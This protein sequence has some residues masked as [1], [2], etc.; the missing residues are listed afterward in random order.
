[1][2]QHNAAIHIGL[3]HAEARLSRMRRTAAGDNMRTVTSGRPDRGRP[4]MVRAPRSFGEG[5][6]AMLD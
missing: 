1:M 3:A 5:Q 2:E 6:R 4:I